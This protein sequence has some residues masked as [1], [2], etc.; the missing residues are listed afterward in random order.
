MLLCLECYKNSLPKGVKIS[1]GQPVQMDKTASQMPIFDDY[2]QYFAAHDL[3]EKTK[4]ST[5]RLF[6]VMHKFIL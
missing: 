3:G 1:L 2:A 5:W 6:T 4:A